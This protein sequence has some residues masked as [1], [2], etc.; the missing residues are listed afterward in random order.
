MVDE[1]NIFRDP[2]EDTKIWRYLDTGKFISMLDKESIVFARVDKLE[3]S[4]E[5]SYSKPSFELRKDNYNDLNK[6]ELRKL[7]ELF[8]KLKAYTFVNCWHMN[9]NESAAMWELYLRAMR[10]WRFKALIGN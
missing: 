9:D 7:S 8:K 10:E 3:D 6:D 2:Q 5:G 1:S 4:F